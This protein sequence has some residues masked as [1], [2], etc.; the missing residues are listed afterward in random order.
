MSIRT[1][2][3][4][5]NE[6]IKEEY[7]KAYFRQLSSQVNMAYRNGPVYPPASQVF[8]AFHLCSFDSLKVVIIGQDPYHGAG[9]AHGLCFSVNEGIALPPS[10]QNIFKELSGDIP[11]FRTPRSG[12]LEAWARQGVLLLNAILTVAAGTPGSHRSFGWETFTDALI[13][14]ISERKEHVVFMLWGNYAFSKEKLING[15]RHLVLKAAHPSPLAR[16]AFFGCRHFSQANRFLEEHGIAP[17][18]W[19]L[20]T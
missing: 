4:D 19:Q 13:S 9:Q 17:V 8:R 18:N 3:A 5:W 2:P 1:I 15:K 16:G 7:G 12:N 10:L 20:A 6:L 11:G 14:V